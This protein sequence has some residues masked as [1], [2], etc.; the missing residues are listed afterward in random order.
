M[1]PTVTVQATSARRVTLVHFNLDNT[2]DKIHQCHSRFHAV[3]T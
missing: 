2:D 1:S 3:P